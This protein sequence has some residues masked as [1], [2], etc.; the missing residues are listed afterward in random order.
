MLSLKNAAT[1]AAQ[2]TKATLIQAAGVSDLTKGALAR[3]K[4][5]VPAGGS[6]QKDLN[7]ATSDQQTAEG[8][9]QAAYQALHIYGKENPEID[10]VVHDRK[11]DATLSPRTSDTSSNERYG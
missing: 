8:N 3:A 11:V 9:Y 6:A 7:Q 5:L 4:K 10:R 1:P 2:N